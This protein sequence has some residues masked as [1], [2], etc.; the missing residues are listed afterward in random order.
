[1]VFIKQLFKEKNCRIQLI[2][3][4]SIRNPE[5]VRL[6]VLAA[7]CWLFLETIADARVVARNNTEPCTFCPMETFCKTSSGEFERELCEGQCKT[8]IWARR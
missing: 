4:S 1:M 5:N 6:Q 7:G 2:I 8:W 3:W